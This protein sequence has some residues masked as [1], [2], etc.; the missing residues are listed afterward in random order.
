MIRYIGYVESIDW[1]RNICKVRVPNNDGLGASAYKPQFMSGLLPNR[2][3]VE[4]L[5]DADIPYHLQGLRVGD[6]VYV[7]ESEDSND[8]YAIV[9]FYGGVYKEE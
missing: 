3:P 1:E 9:G 5:Q 8:N 7:L 4:F 6:V 2:P